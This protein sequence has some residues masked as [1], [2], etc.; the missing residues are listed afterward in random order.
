MTDQTDKAAEWQALRQAIITK[1]EVISAIIDDDADQPLGRDVELERIKDEVRALR[2]ILKENRAEDYWQRLDDGH[3]RFF[4][5]SSRR[6]AAIGK[7][8]TA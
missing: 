2:E 3:R 6:M 4:E 8:G 1:C 5:E 7:R